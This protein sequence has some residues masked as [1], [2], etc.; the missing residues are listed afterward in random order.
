MMV[1]KVEICKQF[2]RA[3]S[4]TNHDSKHD[5]LGRFE[6][7]TRQQIIL[8]HHLRGMFLLGSN[9]HPK[10]GPASSWHQSVPGRQSASRAGQ[11]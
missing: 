10:L 11:N 1:P 6:R 3:T 7:P 5:V 2:F 8:L 4:L 9:L